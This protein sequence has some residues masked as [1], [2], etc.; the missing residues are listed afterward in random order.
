MQAC[1]QECLIIEKTRFI[2][3]EVKQFSSLLKLDAHRSEGND[4]PSALLK[5][6]LKRIGYGLIL[7]RKMSAQPA[8]VRDWLSMVA[9]PMK[10]PVAMTLAE[11]SVVM[12]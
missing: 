9:V 6:E 1:N 7:R 4:R 5:F 10:E 11:L 3:E 2:N 8:L 12:P